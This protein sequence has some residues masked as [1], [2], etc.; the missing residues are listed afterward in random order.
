MSVQDNG[1]STGYSKTDEEV[2]AWVKRKLGFGIVDVELT[3]DHFGDILEDTK[4]WFGHR[5]GVRQFIQVTAQQNKTEYI[6]PNHVVEVLDVFLP[7][8]PIGY[9]QFGQDEASLAQGYL[10]GAWFGG[11]GNSAF[12]T[13][14]YPYSD[15]LMRLQYLETIRRITSEP[16]WDYFPETKTLLVSPALSTKGTAGTFLARIWSSNVDPRDI[17]DLQEIDWFLRWALADAK[18]TLGAIRSKFDTLPSVGGEL[19][20]LGDVLKDEGTSEKVDI[21]TEILNRRRSSP[22]ISA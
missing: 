19:S 16:D 11:Q 12:Q 13:S 8:D 18:Q 20:S 2:V 6:L 10:F 1:G 15:L 5:V 3:S 21:N 14:P 22:I 9:T 17:T 4:R 7:R